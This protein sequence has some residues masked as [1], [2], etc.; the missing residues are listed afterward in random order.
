MVLAS[1]LLASVALAAQHTAC[2]IANEDTEVVFDC[3]G[4]LISAVQFASFGTPV[5]SCE[6]S[7]TTLQQFASCHAHATAVL[8][9]E[10]CLGQ[11]T[12]I[13]QATAESLA[14][15]CSARRA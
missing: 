13:F 14:A 3:G 11:A 12:C 10:R 6:N 1:L 4:E 7:G 5:G 8:L 15:S 2:A 9:E